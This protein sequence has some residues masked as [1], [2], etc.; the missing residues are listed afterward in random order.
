MVEHDTTSEHKST[1]ICVER[2]DAVRAEV[3]ISRNSWFSHSVVDK[4][5]YTSVNGI[6]I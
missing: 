5:V 1:D 3:T 6:R 2:D 4:V